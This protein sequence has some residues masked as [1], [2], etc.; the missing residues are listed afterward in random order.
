VNVSLQIGFTREYEA[1]ADQ[2]GAVWVTRAGYDPVELTA[3]LDKIVQSTDGFPDYLPPYLATH[4]FPEDRIHAIEIAAETLHSKRV[5][6][7]ELAAALPLVQARLAFLLK[8]GRTSLNKGV[9]ESS[10]PQIEA[11]MQQA[12][13]IAERGDRDGALLLLSRIDGLE[14]TDP[15][16]PFQIG[17]LLYESGRYD[18]AADSYLRAL[19]LDASRA[20]V[21]F[22]LGEAFE[23]AGQSHRAVYA[24]E[25]AVLRT[26]ETSE[27]RKRSEWEI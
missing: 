14:R 12:K 13:E 1:E 17:E 5:P 2:L 25:Q 11:V 7:P 6:N 9:A 3:F 20:L 22:K 26:T 27:L 8:T 19:R 10:D 16:I 21:F 4:P 18:E 15:R 23:A 24:F